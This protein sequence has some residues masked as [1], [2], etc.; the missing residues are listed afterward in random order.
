MRAFFIL[1]LI[2]VLSACASSHKVFSDFDATANFSQ[3]QSFAWVSSQPFTVQ[4]DYVVSPFITNE[5]M[6]S[7]ENELVAKGY[8]L[9]SDADK[10]DFVVAFTIGARDKIKVFESFSGISDI[11]RWTWGQQ[12]YP[13]RTQVSQ[14]VHQY[15]E[16]TL[17]IDMFDVKKA[18]P[19]WH[20][21]AK[22]RLNAE[23]RAG[24][25]T[26]VAPAVTSILGSFP[27]T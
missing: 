2:L 14:S 22:K 5:I 16:G 26:D 9:A 12:F 25:T 11:E 7:I 1:I 17:A 24:S 6:Q 4:S 3:Y 20:G 27:N 10:A 15:V 13:I 23:Q 19:V 18:S 8:A 21:Y